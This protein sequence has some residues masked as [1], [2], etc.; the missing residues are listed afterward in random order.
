MRETISCKNCR[1]DERNEDPTHFFVVHEH[2]NNCFLNVFILCKID[3]L[4]FLKIQFHRAVSFHLH[5]H[6]FMV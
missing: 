2:V 3:L 5:F 6:L 4:H 1:D